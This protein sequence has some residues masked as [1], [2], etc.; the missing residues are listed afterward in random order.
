MMN[1]SANNSSSNLN[2][3]PRMSTM[4]NPRPSSSTETA[5][6]AP[7]PM[8][9]PRMSMMPPLMGQMPMMMDPRMSMMN[10]Q[11]MMAM[12]QNNSAMWNQQQQ[13]MNHFDS[14]HVSD[15]EDD[16]VPLGGPATGAKH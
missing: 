16:D 9:D 12:Y 10:M 7:P 11:M 15:D 14:A 1:L 3:D 2:L 6:M 8:M 4:N 13:H 5:S